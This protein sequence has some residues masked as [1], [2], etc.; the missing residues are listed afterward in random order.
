M[1]FHNGK[2]SYSNSLHFSSSPTPSL[3]KTH[4]DHINTKFNNTT[5]LPPP[6]Y[7]SF[8]LLVL[9]LQDWPHH[10]YLLL[11]FN[12][13]TQKRDSKKKRK[14]ISYSYKSQIRV[15]YLWSQAAMHGSR[16]QYL[17]IKKEKQRSFGHV[18]FQ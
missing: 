13:R 16:P 10:Y 7:L 8:Q 14:T 18:N 15:Y 3:T 4:K 12:D 6:P 11:R 17:P 2:I 1:D 5:N 9:H